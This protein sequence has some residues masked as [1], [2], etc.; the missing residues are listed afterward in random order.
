[1]DGNSLLVDDDGNGYVL[2]SSLSEDHQC[3]I[4]LLTPDFLHTT[5]IN[6]GF[7]PDHYVEGQLLFKRNGTYYVAYGSC[8]CFCRD[9]S[10]F[11]L[12]SSSSIKGPW[13]RLGVDKNCDTTTVEVC[14]E[15]GERTN[16]GLI[17]NAQGIGL[18]VIPTKNGDA[19]IWQAERWLSA[20][21]N[22][23]NCTNEC[24]PQTPSNN[25]AQSGQYI[26]GNGY[27]YWYPLNFSES[28]D[29][30]QF[31]PFVNNFELNLI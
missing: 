23:P 12:F 17:V 3:S 29:I 13:T 8:C 26:K 4:E 28:G 30:Y 1:M 11:A 2:Y 5:K 18:S 21:Y 22:N 19:Y 7:F 24:V 25:C 15:Y 20:A 14:G 16:G 10:G 31:A 6:Y 27:S 9:G